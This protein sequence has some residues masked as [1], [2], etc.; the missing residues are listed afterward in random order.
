M[1]RIDIEGQK[2][3]IEVTHETDK[4]LLISFV[5]N[6][7]YEGLTEEQRKQIKEDIRDWGKWRIF[8]NLKRDLDGENE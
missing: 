4:S 7:P 5:N 3:H 2:W 1:E 6:N 8:K